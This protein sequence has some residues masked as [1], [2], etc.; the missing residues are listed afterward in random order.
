MRSKGFFKAFFT[1]KVR[2]IWGK[3]T[4]VAIDA[5]FTLSQCRIGWCK[6]WDC[7]QI[8]LLFVDI[9]VEYLRLDTREHARNY[10]ANSK[11][12]DKRIKEW[13]ECHK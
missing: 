7:I 12:T 11:E 3:T 8:H 5:V 13:K 1:P 10:I 4:P 9:I 6:L 2:F